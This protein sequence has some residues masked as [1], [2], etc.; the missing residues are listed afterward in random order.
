MLLQCSFTH[1]PPCGVLLVSQERLASGLLYYR[2]YGNHD[3][4][5]QDQVPGP[6]N[7]LRGQDQVP[8]RS[9]NQ[10]RLPSIEASPA[11]KLL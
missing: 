7:D 2:S 1:K 4:R 10:R 9:N 3:L 6:I 8:D 11:A 5:G